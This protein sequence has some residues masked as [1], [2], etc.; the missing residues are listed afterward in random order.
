MSET[1]IYTSPCSV[2]SLW[3]E[4][5]VYDDRVELHTWFGP[6]VIPFEHLEHMEVAEPIMK[7][8][9]HLRY[10]FTHWPRHIKVDW[11]DLTEHITV[12]KDAGLIRKVHFTP[13]DPEALAKALRKALARFRR[14]HGGEAA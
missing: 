3:Q 14:S 4:Y 5:R 11:A 6:W 13:D 7:A 12:D 1:P 10:D 8:A 9:L 2:K